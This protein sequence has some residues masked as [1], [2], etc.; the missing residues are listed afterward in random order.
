MWQHRTCGTGLSRVAVQNA[1]QKGEIDSVSVS[2][3][4]SKDGDFDPPAEN[5]RI[6]RP[7]DE[8]KTNHVMLH[9]S[10]R[11]NLCVL[12]LHLLTHRSSL[13]HWGTN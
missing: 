10:P 3:S 1:V 4:V 2:W 7:F 5:T 11:F 13:Q 6:E 12:F 8:L 9:P